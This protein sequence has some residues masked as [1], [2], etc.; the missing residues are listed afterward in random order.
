MNNG[1]PTVK[2]N[3]DVMK[4]RQWDSVFAPPP[5]RQ[6]GPHPRERRHVVTRC[7]SAWSRHT[8]TEVTTRQQLVSS[9]SS[10][11]VFRGRL[12]QLLSVFWCRV[13][14]QLESFTSELF[15]V[16]VQDLRT[17]MSAVHLQR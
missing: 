7:C 11:V 2:L 5:I 3:N 16:H 17:E 1:A 15:K 6:T 8:D 4:T 13:V 12:Q 9:R 10:S 14:V